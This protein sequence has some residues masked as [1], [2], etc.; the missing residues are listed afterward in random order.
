VTAALAALYQRSVAA[1]VL[2]DGLLQLNGRIE[3]D[4]V[5]LAS[6]VP[7][8][9]K[10]LAA[11]EGDAVQAG[12]TIASLDDDAARARLAQ[13]VASCD[14]A[15]ARLDAARAEL[16]LLRK[17]VPIAVNSAEA[18]LRAS[19]ATLAEQRA[20]EAQAARERARVERLVDSGSL[21]SQSGE[22]AV[23]A[24]DTADQAA[25]GARAARDKAST[26][27]LDARLGPDR[28]RANEAEVAA[29]D[30][31][32]KQAQALVDEARTDLDDLTVK[33]PVDG[34]ITTRFVDVGQVLSAGTPIVELVDLDRLYLKAFVPESDV[35]KLHVG[36]V[37]RVYTDAFPNRPAAATVRYVAS[38]AEFTP[39]EVQTR[40]ER[41]KLV[42]TV[43]LY[44]DDNRDRRMV[45]GLGGDAIVRWREDVPWTTPRW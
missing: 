34:T 9:L 1:R 13:A 31:A 35:G 42:Y 17:Q 25:L 15:L 44:L 36:S 41:V 37:A 23:L 28:I 27:L 45:P 43:K 6:K 32:A 7:G 19:E 10:V 12:Q 14:V 24:H 38:R 22:R 4:D 2:P 11:R 29:L 21:D 8:R 30:A 40:D 3:G 33:A 26:A 5:T 20:R 16:A 18:A 39:K